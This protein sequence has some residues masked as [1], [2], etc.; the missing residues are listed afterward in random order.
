MVEAIRSAEK[1]VIVSHHSPDGDAIGS[2]IALR[3]IVHDLHREAHLFLPESVPQSFRFIDPEN[4]IRTYDPEKDGDALLDSDLWFCL[5]FNA[6]SRM[7][8]M[9]D[10]LGK[11]EGDVICIDH[12]KSSEPFGQIMFTDETAAATGL[13]L[14]EWAEWQGGPWTE[15]LITAL[16]SAIV[17]DTGGFRHTNTD[18]RSLSIAARLVERGADPYVICHNLYECWSEG[19]LRL[20]LRV[21]DTLQVDRDIKTAFLQVLRS[22][23]EATG[24]GPQ[25][26]EEF[27][28]YG[29]MLE[30]IEVA[31]LLCELRDNQCKA[32]IR[33]NGVV[34]VEEIA[35]S[36]GGGGHQGASGVRFDLPIE[37]AREKLRQ[38]IRSYRQANRK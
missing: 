4:S 36:L 20:L 14:A 34:D 32:S 30:K 29:R 13:L 3:E 38:A 27:V 10:L 23:F 21:L 24:T 33:S 26:L 5:D 6:P 35:R 28:N 9:N 12:H 7:G 11:Y 18:A 16:Y 31:I 25:D 1:V 17:S 8:K 37:E 19:R 15:T 22:D 2:M